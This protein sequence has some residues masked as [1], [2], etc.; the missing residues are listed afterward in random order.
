LEFLVTLA[1][2]RKRGKSME[3]P[4]GGGPKPGFLGLDSLLFIN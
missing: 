2:C 3:A 4:S 1:D